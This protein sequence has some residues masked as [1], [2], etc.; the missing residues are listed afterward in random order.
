[1]IFS[2]TTLTVE[3]MQRLGYPIERAFIY[4]FQDDKP[5]TGKGQL[6]LLDANFNPKKAWNAYAG[7]PK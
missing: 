1:M 5:G 7:F 6:G 3:A 2:L 4:D